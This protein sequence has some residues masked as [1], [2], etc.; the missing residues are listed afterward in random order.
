[1]F[2][3]LNTSKVYLKQSFK[4]SSTSKLTNKQKNYALMVQGSEKWF[5]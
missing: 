4:Q 1:M 5:K 2:S 3:I